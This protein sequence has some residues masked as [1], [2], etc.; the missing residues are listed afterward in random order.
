MRRV[1]RGAEFSLVK[2][3]DDRQMGKPGNAVFESCFSKVDKAGNI[4]FSSH[5][6]QR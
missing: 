3:P 4:I 2:F 6:S 1:G 5:I